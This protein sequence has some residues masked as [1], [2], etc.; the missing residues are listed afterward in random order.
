MF[1]PCRHRSPSVGIWPHTT[2]TH[3][4][5]IKLTLIEGS[6]QIDSYPDDADFAGLYGHEQNNDPACAKSR[7]EYVILVCICPVLWQSK[8]QTETASALSTMEV[9]IIALSHSCHELFPITDMVECLGEAIGLPV[10][11]TKLNVSIWIILRSFNFCIYFVTTI[12]SSE[13]A[14]HNKNHLVLRTNCA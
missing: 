7:T 11:K 12:Y 14:L 1:C 9:E 4:L 8:L 3:G 6:L 13:Q 2:P 10:G 5:I